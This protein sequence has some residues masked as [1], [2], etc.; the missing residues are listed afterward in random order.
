MP[1][2][3]FQ[4]QLTIN[5]NGVR[6]GVALTPLQPCSDPRVGSVK[7][8]PNLNIWC[9]IRALPNLDAA[10]MPMASPFIDSDDSYQRQMGRIYLF[11]GN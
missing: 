3:T 7:I 8:V 4:S 6:V 11:P 10:A 1:L 5:R 9:L 2:S